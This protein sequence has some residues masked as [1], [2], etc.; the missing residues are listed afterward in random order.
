MSIPFDVVF[1]KTVHRI[2]QVHGLPQSELAAKVG[3]SQAAVSGLE[4]GRKTS[5][6]PTLFRLASS[7]GMK[8]SDLLAMVEELSNLEGMQDVIVRNAAKTLSKSDGWMSLDE[9]ERKLFSGGK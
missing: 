6:L 1:G 4:R 3:I 2:R 9:A 7:F 8:A 5:S